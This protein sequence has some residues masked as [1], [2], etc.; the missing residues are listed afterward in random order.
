MEINLEAEP[1][2]FGSIFIYFTASQTN[3][4]FIATS[5]PAGLKHRHT[6]RASVAPGAVGGTMVG[7]W[8]HGWAAEGFGFEGAEHPSPKQT[9]IRLTLSV[10]FVPGDA[11]TRVGCITELPGREILLLACTSRVRLA[12]LQRSP[13]AL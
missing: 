11:E 5:H 10:E 6:G 13:A 2:S 1:C 7:W 4:W 8:D 12:R 9:Y 3:V